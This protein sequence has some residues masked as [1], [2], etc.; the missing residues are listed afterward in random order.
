MVFLMVTIQA[1]TLQQGPGAPR[2]QQMSTGTN[3]LF[4]ASDVVLDESSESLN[5]CLC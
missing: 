5:S 2:K 4:S 1:K 3:L